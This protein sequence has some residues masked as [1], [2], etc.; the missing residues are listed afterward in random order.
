MNEILNIYKPKGVTS[1]DVV[2]EVRQ[3]FPGEKV[4]HGGTLDPMAEGV[5]VVGIGRATKKLSEISRMNKTYQASIT[6]GLSSPTDD[7]DTESDLE[8][9]RKL[10]K[11][12]KKIVEE[13]L[14]QFNGKIEQR[15]P[16]YSATH[17]Q[18]EKLYKRARRGEKIPN[19][20]LPKKEVVISKIELVSFDKDGYQYND[21]PYPL[22]ELEIDCSSG[23]YIRSIARDLGKKLDTLGL[24]A[25]LTRTRIGRFN[26]KDSLKL[27]ELSSPT[28]G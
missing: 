7:L 5:L 13:K 20:K 6:F 24:L 19:S 21:K 2:D 28:D 23:T 9:D 3:K 26:I 10:P 8:V 12:D 17:Y 1:H 4:G 11:I 27:K 15:V 18:G 14:E 22:L 25:S 16:L